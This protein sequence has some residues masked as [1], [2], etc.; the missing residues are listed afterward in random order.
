MQPVFGN[1]GGEWRFAAVRLKCPN[2]R[3]GPSA[4]TS[5]GVAAN[6]SKEPR[7]PD[8]AKR[9]ESAFVDI[10]K[11]FR[12]Y[13]GFGRGNRGDLRRVKNKRFWEATE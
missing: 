5:R 6:G 10:P 11:T 9:T 13:L 12:N 7:V 4:E 2:R 8:D 1:K 3:S